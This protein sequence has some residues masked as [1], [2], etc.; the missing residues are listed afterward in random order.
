MIKT[1]SGLLNGAL[2]LATTV[3]FMNL[4]AT[5]PLGLAL[6]MY[7]PSLLLAVAGGFVAIGGLEAHWDGQSRNVQ[8]CAVISVAW[9]AVQVA[10]AV[11]LVRLMLPAQWLGPDLAQFWMLTG[12]IAQAIL[13]G[14]VSR[15]S[16]RSRSQRLELE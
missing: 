9:T 12:T 10:F 15:T 14:I 1:L 11:L 7:G 2:V 4:I 5:A 6:V 3:G 13:V 16:A 8:F